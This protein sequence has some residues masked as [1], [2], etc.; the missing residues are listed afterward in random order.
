M[1]DHVSIQCDDV[2]RSAAFYDAVLAPLGGGRAM[3]FEGVIGYG[4]GGK[5]VFWI[6]PHDSGE[7]FRESHFA[8]VAA[9][10]AAV[11][12]FFDAAAAW[13]AELLHEPKVWVEYHPNYYGAFVRD[14]D[15][16]N[17]EAVCHGAE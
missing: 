5:P 4:I 13:G 15:G 17:V 7:G 6:G 3:E 9:E 12:D 2:A 16:N 11:R 1:L 10:R 8:F 14:P